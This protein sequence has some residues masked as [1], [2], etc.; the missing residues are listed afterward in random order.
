M[1][2]RHPY[3]L[4]LVLHECDEPRR[5]SDA[6]FCLLTCMVADIELQSITL[7][8]YIY[9]YSTGTPRFVGGSDKVRGEGWGVRARVRVRVRG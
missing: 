9:I 5:V 3:K 7:G 4:E 8:R 2:T 6:L 1:A